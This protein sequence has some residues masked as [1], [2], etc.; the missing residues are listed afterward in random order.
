LLTTEKF[1][2]NNL[3]VEV[4]SQISYFEIGPA[5][6]GKTGL[7]SSTKL[8]VVTF[9]KNLSLQLRKVSKNQ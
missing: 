2:K 3:V 7:N 1:T 5:D 4:N 6:E 9:L 8:K